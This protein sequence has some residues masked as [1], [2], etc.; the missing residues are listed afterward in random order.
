VTPL[1]ASSMPA[2]HALPALATLLLLAIAALT[3]YAL[4]CAA[5]PFAR[6]KKCEG[7]G[8]IRRH[9]T[10]PRRGWKDCRRC[11]G[12]GA[13]LRLGRRLYHSGTSTAASVRKLRDTANH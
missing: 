5:F 9:G 10:S 12:N 7:N 2:A 3:A 6:C 8:K 13:R 1:C 4:L 11:H